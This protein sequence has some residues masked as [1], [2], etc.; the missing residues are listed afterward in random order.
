MIAVFPQFHKPRFTW[1]GN[2]DMINYY[3]MFNWVILEDRLC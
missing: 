3:D 2:C 1:D